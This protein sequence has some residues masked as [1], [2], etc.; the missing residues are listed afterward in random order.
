MV[1]ND[2]C[3]KCKYKCNAI[4]FQQNFVGWTSGND[5]IDKFIQD[6]QLSVHNVKYKVYKKALEWIT[7]DRFDNIIKSRFDETYRANWI[8]GC[9]CEWD[10]K[11]QNWKRNEN[12][13]V[14]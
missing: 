9:I 8:D 6:T 12:M 5:Y 4:H 11:N 13:I 7:F 10:G 2:E 1:L 3:K 14:I